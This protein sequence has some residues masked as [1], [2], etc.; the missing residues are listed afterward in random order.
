[1]G[2][3]L[4]LFGCCW[5][6]A[7]VVPDVRLDGFDATE[8]PGATEPRGQVYNA[9]PEAA[10]IVKATVDPASLVAPL[11]QAIHGV[12]PEVVVTATL[13]EDRISE[14][15]ARPRFYL[16]VAGLFG[17]VAL[18][19]AMLGLYGVIAH[20]VSRRTRE[21]GIRIALGAAGR[22]VRRLVL[23]Q[24]LTPVIAGLAIGLIGTLALRASV[25]KFLYGIDTGDPGIVLGVAVALAA[26]AAL[27]CYLPARRASVV[28][29]VQSLTSE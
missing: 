2:K 4:G 13:V 5:T 9:W 25:E 17:G 29:P 24:A 18:A 11:R 21:I 15:L 8:L 23:G 20:S 16:L 10:L 6:V 22:E 26:S 12:D 28:D 19:M 1:M 3:R 27:A 14:A 7:G